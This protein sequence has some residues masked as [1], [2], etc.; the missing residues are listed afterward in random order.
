MAQAAAGPRT[1][2]AAPPPADRVEIVLFSDFQCPFCAVLAQ[3]VRELEAKGVDGTGITVTFK[4]FPLSIHPQAA[5]AHRAALAATQQGKF[6]EMHDLLFA[7][8]RKAERDDVLEYARR[9]GL[10]LDRFQKDLDSD[11][12]RARIASDQAE[13]ETLHVTGTPTYY[14]NGKPYFG[15]RSY[16]QLKLLI[17]GSQRRARAMSDVTDP[18]AR[19]PSRRR[20]RARG[21]DDRR[22]GRT[23]LGVRAGGA[24]EPAADR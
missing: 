11:E 14:V 1:D 9:L 19:V 2:A 8:Q 15:A 7:N 12:T 17:A 24:R 20:A 3:P 21:R 6:W 18:A 10:D 4:H 23:V 22:Q 13:G 16:E 5:L